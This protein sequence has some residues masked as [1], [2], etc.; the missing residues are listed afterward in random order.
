MSSTASS[1]PS[2]A[3]SSSKLAEENEQHGGNKENDGQYGGV[4]ARLL[5]ACLAASLGSFSFGYNLGSLNA[6]LPRLKTCS[7]H[8]TSTWSFAWTAQCFAI[9]GSQEGLASSL[10]CFGALIGCLGAGRVVGKVGRRPLLFANAVLYLLG[11]LVLAASVNV[12]MLYVGRLLVGL[13][14]GTTCVAAP[15][16]LSECSPRRHRG[17]FGSLHQMMIVTGYLVSMAV[18]LGLVSL[19]T[20]ESGA[21]SGRWRFVLGLNAVSILLQIVLL[22]FSPESPVHFAAS[23]SGAKGL[24]WESDQA[25]AKARASL[26]CL[27]QQTY[28]EGELILLV[29]PLLRTDDSPQKSTGDL[30]LFRMI[31]EG[32]LGARRSLLAVLLLH[33]VQQLSG[34]N[35]VFYFSTNLFA[36]E[37]K[38]SLNTYVPLLIA[39][40]NFVMT[41]VALVLMDRAGRKKLLVGSCIGMIAALSLYTGSVLTID[42]MESLTVL[43]AASIVGYIASFA[44]GMGP[45]PW[46]MMNE[47]FDSRTVSSGVGLGVAVNWLA[48]TLVVAVFPYMLALR[49]FIFTP[50]IAVLVAFLAW[51]VA[52]LPETKGRAPQLL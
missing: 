37:G 20:S 45:V 27:R 14:V 28:D 17:V 6:V 49:S 2:P 32:A 8:L 15:M 11:V 7:R 31:R 25:V 44:V 21:S 46:L 50:F 24:D 10:L 48:N 51:A 18:G 47:I 38:S 42:D 40:V 33:L 4:T 19:D 30:G 12:P 16:Y 39:I 5:M 29:R 26:K 52:R 3:S 43:K 35:G 23:A 13:G 34:I 9:T 1:S 41:V 22:V 36:G